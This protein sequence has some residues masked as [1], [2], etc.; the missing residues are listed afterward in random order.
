MHYGPRYKD[1]VIIELED[2]FLAFE[3][4]YVLSLYNGQ[5]AIKPV[6]IKKG[7]YKVNVPSV[8]DLSFQMSEPV[9]IGIGQQYEWSY[10]KESKQYLSFSKPGEYYMVTEGLTNCYTNLELIP[11]E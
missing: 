5:T 4:T 6:E 3:V 7:C 2:F 8:W 10:T 11:T 9:Y 1:E